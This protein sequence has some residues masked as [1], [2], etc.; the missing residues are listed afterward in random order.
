MEES[1]C[2]NQNWCIFQYGESRELCGYVRDCPHKCQGTQDKSK[3]P[4]CPK[5]GLDKHQPES[6]GVMLDVAIPLCRCTDD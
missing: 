3:S 6:N 4:V 2:N 5:C 1:N